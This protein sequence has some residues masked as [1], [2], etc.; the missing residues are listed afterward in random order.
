MI[1]EPRT[2]VLGSNLLKANQYCSVGPMM[3]TLGRGSLLLTIPIASSS[4]Y[5]SDK[6]LG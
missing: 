3:A 4:G 6:I 5:G 1:N 2:L